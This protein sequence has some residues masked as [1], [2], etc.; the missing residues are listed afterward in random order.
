MVT[1][2]LP[3]AN[4]KTCSDYI[5]LICKSNVWKNLIRSTWILF[6]SSNYKKNIKHFC[7]WNISRKKRTKKK[8]RK[9][10]KFIKTTCYNTIRY[11]YT[12]SSTITAKLNNITM[13]NNKSLFFFSGNA[14]LLNYKQNHTFIHRHELELFFFLFF[15]S[16]FC[17]FE[18]KSLWRRTIENQL[19]KQTFRQ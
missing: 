3:F 6:I 11:R 8:H 14:Q 5:C 19:H 18:K 1:V 15:C 7:R 9:K 16:F 12:V 2:A 4:H 13:N 10:N 17:V